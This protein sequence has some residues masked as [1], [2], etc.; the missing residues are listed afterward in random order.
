MR[1]TAFSPILC[2]IFAIFALLGHFA[3]AAPPP[4]AHLALTAPSLSGQVGLTWNAAMGATSYS[5]K[6]ATAQNGTFSAVGSPTTTSFTDTTA[7]A[8][9][10]Y[11][12]RVTA[13]DGTG[14]GAVSLTISATPA[15]VVDNA[16]ATGVTITG[17][18][19]ASTAVAGFYG[20]N[21][22]LDGNTGGTGGKSV[23]FTPTLPF[24]GRYD[25]YLRWSSDATRATNVR[26]EVNS[27]A[28]TT[29]MKVNEQAN[30]GTWVKLGAFDFTAGTGG[31]VLMRNN[32]ANGWVVADAVQ[33]VLNEQPL[34]G[35]T[36]VT[37]ADEFDGTAYDTATWSVYDSRPNNLVSGGQLHLTTTANGTGWDEG[38]LYTSQ[39]MQR[40][41]YFETV[42]QVGRS[43]GLN[44][45]FWLYTPF[46]H[47][48]NVDVLEMDITEAHFHDE[49]HM[50]VHDWKPTHVASGATQSVADIYPGY[51]T[52]GLE[53][54]TDGVLRWY[55][56]GAL[57]RTMTTAQ[58]AAYE[59][60][61]PMQVMFST[62]VIAFAGTPGSLM[63]GSSMDIAS[64]RVWMKPGWTGAF[65]GNWG[66][67]TN[68]GPDG[69]PGSGEAAVFN[70]A[71]T[72]TTVSLLSDKSVK[73]LYFTTPQCPPMTLAAGSFKFLLGALASG[74]G[75]GGIVVNGDATTA[76][77]INTAIQAQNDLT[78]ANYCTAA[79]AALNINGA[80]TSSATGRQ[81]T[82]AGNGRMTVG[83]SISAGF[84]S[85]V[86]VNAGATWLTNANAFTGEVDVQNGKLVVTHSGALGTTGGN[87]T[88]ASGA[89]LALAG[90]VNF[91][92]A[93]TVRLAGNGEAGTSGALDVEDSSAV[94]F[95]GLLVMDAAARIG[96]GAATGTLT[97]TSG[98]D[99]TA[100]AFAL[101]FAGSGT[102][103][104]N[105]A[106]TGA[107]DLLKTGTGAL[108]L[109]GLASHTGTTTVSQG[110][111]ITNLA[112]LSGAVTNNATVIFD[113][114][115]DR[116]VTNNWG[117]TGN[118]IKQGA[119]T[120]TFSGTMSAA[121]FLELQVGT[122]RLAGNERFSSALDLIVN[123][124][125][126]FDLN[127]FT[128]TCGPV[129]L[130]GGSIVN[131]TGTSAQFLAGSTYD[132]RS[133]TISV[134]LG[135]PG[136]LM[137]TTAG[138]VTLSGA[139]TFTGG[140]T[141]Q[142]G[143]L[144]LVGSLS[145][146]VTVDGGT[147]AL[148]TTTGARTVNGSLTINAAG[149]LRIRINGTT[150]GTQYDQLRLTNAASAVTL[151]GTLDLVAA[152]GLAAGGTFRI[153]DNSGSSTAITGTFTGLPESA[154]FYEDGQWWRIS[155][156][157]GT[158]ND[159]VLTRLTPTAWQSWQAANFGTA[160]NDPAIAGA[161]ADI[162]RDG[163][164]NLMEFALLLDPNTPSTLPI[165]I[166]KNGATLE[167]TYTRSK[168]AFTSGV[169]FT[170]EWSDTLA[171]GSWSMTG[172]SA[173]VIL[174]DNGVTQQI[175]V[176]LPAGI[177]VVGR[178]VHLNVTR[179]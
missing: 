115:T 160:T 58:L 122:V 47:S 84:S 51:H 103:I 135:G 23:R 149:S 168:A 142:A 73:E 21:Y 18:W 39:F 29:F 31:N 139:N 155:Y 75:V 43:D 30:G 54:G 130:R 171:A 106:I 28:G 164:V 120:F 19:S 81:L 126:V 134:R 38:G 154:E 145:S 1:R 25:V 91:T 100:G 49:N 13:I 55:W 176:T 112:A 113:D 136:A 32:G 15:I 153:I 77:T 6:R 10:R 34:P 159:V 144:D 22:L 12:Y 83:G 5:V 132:V 90:G 110:T 92:S 67:T 16:D 174:S 125:A 146:S 87:T 68:W 121:G 179:P 118:Y 4:P 137:K 108:W 76:Q 96:S 26:V 175:K 53:W 131:S 56:D 52:A 109:N 107:G 74:T 79:T 60:M 72:R 17:A 85:V 156:S 161:T 128:E 167:F 45:A 101:S 11:F 99:T 158:G 123:T 157:G 177:G 40:F 97:L 147:L 36:Q 152:P 95:G 119:G 172:V 166:V 42:M 50:T 65:D 124:G 41:G 116:T 82:L 9:T 143:T 8:G 98:L 151:A 129:E 173:P 138:T 104:M 127:A 71:T 89:T 48:N 80:L 24:A 70:G 63:N 117:G 35:Y 64:V 88:V 3:D 148:G 7:T 169:I 14:E 62:K 94:S 178:F 46:S 165:S 170:V 37:F 114:G 105:G 86:K 27:T 140:S 59:G 20:T 162:E 163:I 2:L 66:T 69:V 111:L 150:V 141:V 61:T 133:G 102:T 78:F 33:L 44:N 57:V 93:E